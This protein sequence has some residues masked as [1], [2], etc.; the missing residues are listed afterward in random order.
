LKIEDKVN[1]IAEKSNAEPRM[2]RELRELFVPPATK[3]PFLIARELWLDRAFL[4]LITFLVLFELMLLVKQF[5]ALSFFWVFIP[6]FLLLPFFLFYSRSVVSLV[7]SYKEPDERI[8]A[9]ASA[10][11]NVQ[12]IVYGHTHIIRHELIGSVEHLNSG[13]WSPA[14]KDVECTIPIDQKTF[15]WIEPSLKGNRQARV[16]IFDQ[17]HSREAFRAIHTKTAAKRS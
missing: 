13:C 2:V 17:D 7:S 11:T 12:R 10:I 5:F 1:R 6:L 3:N 15:V 8:L 16:F 9:T 4:L 14:F